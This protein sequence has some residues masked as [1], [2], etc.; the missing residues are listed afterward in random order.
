VF[1]RLAPPIIILKGDVQNIFRRLRRQNKIFKTVVLLILRSK[2]N[3]TTVL[4][5]ILWRRKHS[6]GL[7]T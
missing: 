5:N 4:K 1:W 2:I 7:F 3:K 6:Q